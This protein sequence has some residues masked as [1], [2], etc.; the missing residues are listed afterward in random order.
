MAIL[1]FQLRGEN[2]MSPND[3]TDIID[4][5]QKLNGQAA[6]II[7]ILME[8]QGIDESIQNTLWAVRDLV[9]RMDSL[10]A[11]LHRNSR[12]PTH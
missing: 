2:A 1:D 3:S 8:R 5:L 7:T 9:L 4:E 10:Q 11:E 12:L 6:G